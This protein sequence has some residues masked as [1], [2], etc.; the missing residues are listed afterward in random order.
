MPAR[1]QCGAGPLCYLRRGALRTGAALRRTS[2]HFLVCPQLQEARCRL[3]L[4][5]VAAGELN[6][7]ARCSMT[8]AVKLLLRMAL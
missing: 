6:S 7:G 8:R 5:R 4:Q 3:P 2:E 1:T